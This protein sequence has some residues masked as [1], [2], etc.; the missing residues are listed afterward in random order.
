MKLVL[1]IENDLSN[2]NKIFEALKF[3]DPQLVARFF[4]NIED[5]YAWLKLVQI[6]GVASLAKAGVSAPADRSPPPEEI[7][8][9]SQIVL[10]IVSH[11]LFNCQKFGLVKKVHSFL[12][13][14]ALIKSEN[15]TGIV[16]TTFDNPHEDLRTLRDPLLK[17]IIYKPFDKL[18]LHQH[19]EYALKP[20]THIVP[21]AVA[22][23]DAKVEI[24]I[25]KNVPLTQVSEIGFTIQL[26][27]QMELGEPH[28]FYHPLFE[29]KNQNHVWARLA[30][31]DTEAGTGEFRHF[32]A[33]PLQVR[34]I[35]SH[36]FEK[37]HQVKTL[38]SVADKKIKILALD[39][40]PPLS[41]EV[42]SDLLANFPEGKFAHYSHFAQAIL[43]LEDKESPKR[44]VLPE[45]FTAVLINIELLEGEGEQRADFILKVLKE[46][47]KRYAREDKASPSIYLFGTPRSSTKTIESW[48]DYAEDFFISPF[49][50][51]YAL[52]KILS[53]VNY[54][55]TKPLEI[56]TLA[57]DKAPSQEIKIAETV[58]VSKISEASLSIQSKE[59]L[60]VGDFRE[61]IFESKADNMEHRLLAR[62]H[63]ASEDSLSKSYKADL[64]FYGVTDSVLKQVRLWLLKNYIDSKEGAA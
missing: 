46:R 51:N 11:E 34:K 55:G 24:D 54:A 53:K 25:L 14:K 17:N 47:A 62:V 16:I 21:S 42:F 40:N 44:K 49:D 50:K 23:I 28:K 7:P 31:T 38:P 33:T 43:D 45:F 56:A 12:S 15:A 63:F 39:S 6:D 27:K 20:D 37:S 36:I 5:F 61:V 58:H 3:V 64:V 9:E 29:V 18:M 30:N 10:L 4:L 59:K 41:L 8:Q 57:S 60:E 22:T 52:K 35:H 13:R 26:P 32:A 48:L 1:T 19:L 2:Q